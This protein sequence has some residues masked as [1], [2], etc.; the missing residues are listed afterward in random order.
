M[1]K[2]PE[3][4]RLRKLN[5]NRLRHGLD[6]LSDFFDFMLPTHAKEWKDGTFQ[7]DNSTSR[8]DCSWFG[9]M[10]LV[11]EDAP[12]SSVDLARHLDPKQIA[13]ECCSVGILLSSPRLSS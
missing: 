12:F 7:W 10:L 2:L 6:E 4:I 5:W 13:I 9:F 8:T 1:R 3:F 11:K